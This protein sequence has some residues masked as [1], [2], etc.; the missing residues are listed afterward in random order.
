MEFVFC[1][2][3]KTRVQIQPF[4]STH[5]ASQRCL[6]NTQYSSPH[7]V[8]LASRVK[9]SLWCLCTFISKLLIPI[10]WSLF[11]PQSNYLIAAAPSHVLKLGMA[12]IASH[13]VLSRDCWTFQFGG[14]VFGLVCHFFEGLCVCVCVCV[15]VCF[16]LF[17]CF[18]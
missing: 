6:L 10:H 11:L 14:A 12:C 16:C 13:I 1:L 2:G 3:T 9:A 17:V 18:Y 8:F 7:G 15:C 4:V 5:P